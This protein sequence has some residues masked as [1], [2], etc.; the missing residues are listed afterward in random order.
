MKL[1]T[2]DLQVAC[3]KEIMV[4]GH[5]KKDEQPIIMR[6]RVVKDDPVLAQRIF[7]H[8]NDPVLGALFIEE[9]QGSEEYHNAAHFISAKLVELGEL[10]QAL[11]FIPTKD[12]PVDNILKYCFFEEDYG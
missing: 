9:Y 10:E 8:R 12:N 5:R 6:S 2:H 3:L 4:N 1:N 7:Y 11:D